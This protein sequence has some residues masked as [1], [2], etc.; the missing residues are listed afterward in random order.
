MFRRRR[1][2]TFATLSITLW[3]LSSAAYPAETK[4]LVIFHATTLTGYVSDLASQFEKAHPGVEVQ[5]ESSGSLIAI[6]KV[7]DLHLPCD[8]VMS[9]DWRLLAQPQP[10]I[11][12]WDVIFAGNS[13]G[14]LYS[15]RSAHAREINAK[16]WYQLI[17]R[18]GVRY[19]HS[20]PARDPEGYWT[21]VVWK[22]A[23]SYY[24]VPGLADQLQAH[25]P[26][27]N[28]RSAD[29]DLISLVQAGELDYYFGYASEAHLGGLE[30]LALP[31]EINL[32][33]SRNEARYESTK[34]EICEGDSCR[35]IRGALAAYGA[36]IASNAPNRALAIEF[37]KSMLGETGQAAAKRAGLIP[38][39]KAFALDPGHRMPSELTPLVASFRSK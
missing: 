19:G 32:G 34:V 4:R 29:S 6:R 37:I 36:S 38:Y 3:I 14:L 13:M 20:D 24:K 15:K 26:P 39:A 5:R 8:I 30:F 9:A 11:E 2:V 1:Y 28:I 35:V 21:L 31:P 27:S 16:N 23:E 7:A 17:M 22:L 18:Q 25:C 10:G 33:D 12:P